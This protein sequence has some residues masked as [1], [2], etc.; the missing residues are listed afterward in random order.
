M[1]VAPPWKKFPGQ[2]GPLVKVYVFPADTHGCGCYRLKWPAQALVAQGHDVVIVS[3]G[4]T[5][6]MLMN[7][8]GSAVWVLS[9][10]VMP[11]SYA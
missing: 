4:K 6:S 2:A 10:S 11:P 9:V 5:G 8:L 3:A 1:G 7:W